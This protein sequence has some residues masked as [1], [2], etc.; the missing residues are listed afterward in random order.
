MKRLS[1]VPFVLAAGMVGI[2]PIAQASTCPTEYY[3][4]SDGTYTDTSGNTCTP[5]ANTYAGNASLFN[6]CSQ[7]YLQYSD[8]SYTNADGTP[9]TPGSS[10]G[11]A[12]NTTPSA[13]PNQTPQSSGFTALAPIPGLTDS[14]TANSVI[15]SQSLATF[16]NN[17]YKYM[18]GLAAA[19]AVIMIIWGGLEISTQDSVSKNK[20]GKEKIY[21]AIFGL[22][23][24]LSP[25][26]VFS[27]INPAILNLSLNLPPLKTMTG[28]TPAPDLLPGT[29]SYTNVGVNSASGADHVQVGDKIISLPVAGHPETI[30]VYQ[31]AV[32]PA[33][34]DCTNPHGTFTSSGNPHNTV[35]L[36]CA[37]PIQ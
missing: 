22:V 25:A 18:I 28:Q 23:L 11:V 15:N 33:K 12:A 37:I 31:A 4:M 9:C 20:D 13:T 8:G 6:T 32:T 35:T 14:G 29:T 16:F 3:Q 19:L 10:S 27:I 34:T 30:S 24:V 1:F 36:K 26:L 2:V 7:G 17:L 5:G 21:N